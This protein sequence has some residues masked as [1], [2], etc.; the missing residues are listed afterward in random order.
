MVEDHADL[1]TLIYVDIAA[2]EGR[3]AR[4]FYEGLTERFRFAA[5]HTFCRA[6]NTLPQFIDVL[7]R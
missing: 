4:P 7:P 5:E 2:F 3:H 1:M 6:I